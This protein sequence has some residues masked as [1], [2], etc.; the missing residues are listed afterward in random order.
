M[1]GCVSRQVCGDILGAQARTGGRTEHGSG[2]VDGDTLGV[3][4]IGNRP[5]SVPSQCESGAGVWQDAQSAMT[6]DGGVKH[7]R[8]AP[9]W[10]VRTNKAGS[11]PARCHQF[12]SPSLT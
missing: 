2:G 7:V 11:T 5:E 6:T 3:R 10:E 8:F 12:L 9:S 1:I 4:R